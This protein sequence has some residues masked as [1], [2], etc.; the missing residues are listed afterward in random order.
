LTSHSMRQD[1]YFAA[2]FESALNE[3]PESL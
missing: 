1:Q 2:H 3:T